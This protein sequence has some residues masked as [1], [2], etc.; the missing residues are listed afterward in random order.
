LFDMLGNVSEWCNN[1]H[2]AQP[3][4]Q[5]EQVQKTSGFLPL[6][7]Y[8]MRGNDYLSNAR[9]LRTANRRST[10][11]SEASYARGFRIAHTVLI[12]KSN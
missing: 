1:I 6:G 12:P 5:S 11:V 3:G 7:R 2:V 8:A 10:L 4:S 9:M